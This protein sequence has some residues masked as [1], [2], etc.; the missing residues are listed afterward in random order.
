MI[1]VESV[2][3]VYTLNEIETKVAMEKDSENFNKK[4]KK[5]IL[6][7][8]NQQKIQTSFSS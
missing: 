4:Q 2:L 5:K 1:F 7:T 6:D 8:K 3:T